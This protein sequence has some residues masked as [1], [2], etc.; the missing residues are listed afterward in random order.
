MSSKISK[1]S[2]NALRLCLPL[3]GLAYVFWG[4]DFDAL[5]V[6]LRVFG[7]LMIAAMILGTLL[8]LL[9]ML[10]RLN[11][12]SGNTLGFSR[13]APATLVG[14]GMNNIL[15]AK[16]GEAAKVFYIR[17]AAGIRKSHGME[18]V[19]WERF[20]DLNILLALAAYVLWY[21]GRQLFIYPL[22][23]L[24]AATWAVLLVFRCAPALSLRLIELVRWERARHSL[25]LFHAAI[26]NRF[27]MRF[28]LVLALY[29]V[30]FWGLA[31]SVTG[32]AF[33]AVQAPLSPPQWL[34]VFVV[35]SLGMALPGAPGGLGVYEAAVVVPSLWFGVDK[36]T[37]VAL[38]VVLRAVQYI[39]VTLLGLVA[40]HFSGMTVTRFK[41]EDEAASES[42]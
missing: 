37:A 36:G 3:A 23:A 26:V 21:T 13:A 18:L 4:I 35:S 11:F 38:A 22:F 12:L 7:P 41:Q 40:L 2:L 31:A 6:N 10:L 39:P 27:Q 30:F 42:F 24:V 5:L 33:Y 20:S 17:S 19:F 28:F 29:S 15:P 25:L 9:P 34:A 32:L 14:Q 1:V 16:L 8:S